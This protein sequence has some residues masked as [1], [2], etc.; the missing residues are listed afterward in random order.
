[1]KVAAL[2]AV[3]IGT[4]ACFVIWFAEDEPAGMPR[5]TSE[6]VTGFS[7]GLVIGIAIGI[8]IGM[9]IARQLRKDQ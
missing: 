4:I 8:A 7:S 2:V 6:P 9:A 3:V 1:M 5:G